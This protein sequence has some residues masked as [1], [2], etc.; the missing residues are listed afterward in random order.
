ML[1]FAV[2]QGPLI[3]TFVPPNIIPD[4]GDM[5]RDPVK[6]EEADECNVRVAY[7]QKMVPEFQLRF[8]MTETSLRN[9]L[10]DE[11]PLLIGEVSRASPKKSVRKN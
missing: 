1:S 9:C 5:V 3:F 6:Y 8:V 2:K 11:W 7:N 4:R 10:D